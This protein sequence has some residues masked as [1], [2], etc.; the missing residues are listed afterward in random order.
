MKIGKMSWVRH[1]AHAPGSQMKLTFWGT[2]G[3][4]ARAGPE[5]RRFGGNTSCVSLESAAGTQIVLDCG[6]GGYGLARSLMA[7]NHGKR[8]HLLFGHTH[9]DHIQGLP[10]FSPLF[11][12][13]ND[14][15]IYGPRGIGRTTRDLLAGQMQYDYFPVELD[16]LAA[17][18]RY[19]DLVEGS[20]DIDDIKV[21]A[22]YLNHPSLTLA[23]R[24]E[25]DGITVVYSTDHE[26]RSAL[27][28]LGKRVPAA[29][30]DERHARFLEGADLL[31]HD[32]QY[33]AE[34]Y[35]EKRGWGHSTV[36]YV[37]DTAEAVGVKN[38]A[39]FHHDPARDDDDI[40]AIEVAAQTRLRTGSRTAVFAAAEG[41]TIEM[42]SA[43]PASSP[44][45]HQ[46]S[47]FSV[48]ALSASSCSFLTHIP[49][50]EEGRFVAAALEAE[51]LSHTRL[52]ATTDVARQLDQ[53]RPTAVL[54]SWVGPETL[55][56]A[57]KISQTR[58]RQP[59]PLILVIAKT[60]EEMLVTEGLGA[61]IR[62]YFFLPTSNSYI[63]TWLRSWILRLS[64]G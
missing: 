17:A 38:L 57:K 35:E 26:P 30:E 10:F 27:L 5:T 50:A 9:W 60:E 36:E 52:R 34:E 33:L 11:A 43:Q 45:V 18:V 6:T 47:A 61:G 28:A 19:H 3:S 51:G 14:W 62:D 55:D 29:G 21:T 40:S 63:R 24:L 48:P 46:M 53:V 32:A 58:S 39:L 20:F 7:N 2:R 22:Q 12:P 13:G 64:N 41:H 54:L 15:D 42:E 49:Q 16:E 25:V 37:V 56:L 1:R 8:G 4:I 59:A 31:I 23:Y 44:R